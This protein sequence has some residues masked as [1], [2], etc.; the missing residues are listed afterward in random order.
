M[1]FLLLLFLPFLAGAQ[2]ADVLFGQLVQKFKKVN[3]YE[4]VA[5][6]KPSIPMI[7]I[8]PVRANIQF[9]YPNAYKIQSA[10][11]SILPKNGF[12]ELPQLF[13]K[14]NQFTVIASGQE[15]LNGANTTILT[16]LPLDNE[17]DLIL[18]KIWVNT[19]ELLVMKSLVTSRSNGSITSTF[20]YGDEKKWG[21]PTT[22]TFT[23]DVKKFKIPKG[24][25]TDINRASKALDDKQP[26]GKIEIQFS[27]YRVN[28]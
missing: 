2:Q 25:A 12:S 5:Q 24:I 3:H 20:L 4:V 22:M 23:M 11:I 7:R 28:E 9:Q 19:Q 15:V 10:G 27:K 21:L 13:T 17:G 16:L 1:K 6:I 18:A 26:K 14:P 8:L